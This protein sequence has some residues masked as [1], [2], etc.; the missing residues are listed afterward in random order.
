[1]RLRG[2]LIICVC[3]LASCS[4]DDSERI[5]EIYLD[6]RI[7]LQEFQIKKNADNILLVNNEGVAGLM[8]C[9]RADGAYVAFDRCSSVEPQK[10]CQVTPDTGGLTATDPCSSAKFSL[11]DGAAVKAP[12]V[13]PLKEYQVNITGFEIV[14]FN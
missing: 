10:K 5:P 13:R 4:K 12:A 1:M 3:F 9:R 8:I 14:V 6:Y 7:S 2:L 11:Y